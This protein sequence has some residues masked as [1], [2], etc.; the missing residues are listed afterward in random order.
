M[1]R[2][3]LVDIERSLV[4]VE[5]LQRTLGLAGDDA[6]ALDARL[7]HLRAC[8]LR[9]LAKARLASADFDGARMAFESA[10]AGGAD[11]RAAAAGVGLRL[12]PRL[13]R[14]LYVGRVNGGSRDAA[15]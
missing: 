5:K 7:R 1:S 9:E 8:R 11:W 3:A 13:V 6:I 15:S 10:A 14:R 2:S 4:V 12:A